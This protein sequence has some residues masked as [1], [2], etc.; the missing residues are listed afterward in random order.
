MTE[1]PEQRVARLEAELA[2]AKVEALQKQ[3][4]QAQS[5]AGPSSHLRGPVQLGKSFEPS[6]SLASWTPSGAGDSSWATFL[7]PSNRSQS[8]N[9]AD[10]THLAAAP[11]PVPFA[12]RVISIP[13]SFWTL[14]ALFMIAIAPIAV[15]I[16]VPIA[17]VV[18]AIATFL[19]VVGMLLRK[20]AIR[21]ALLKWGEVA[22]VTTADPL[23]RGT[24]YSGTTV[25]NVRMAQAHGWQVEHQW[26]SGPVTKT[27]VDYDLHGTKGSLV[28]RGLD[29][30]NG[31]IL[32]DSREPRRALCVSSFPYDL[33]RDANGNWV[34]RVA[35]RIKISSAVMIVLLAGWTL[36]MCWI[37]GEQAA[38]LPGLVRK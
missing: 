12:F 15:W 13:L 20:S 9:R 37:W 26:Y 8:S 11:R 24:Y 34:G 14:F 16:L 10:D 7:P 22:T 27:R 4:A 33:S 38:Q 25:S 5:E 30:D 1:T 21:T 32:A 19:I 29:Y 6:P 18:V 2:Q 31:V 3:L 28:I 23:S 35:T 17:G 36:G